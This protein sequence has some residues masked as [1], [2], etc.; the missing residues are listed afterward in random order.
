MSRMSNIFIIL[1]NNEHFSNDN[2]IQ[3]RIKKLRI[4]ERLKMGV[5]G[6]YLLM[7]AQILHEIKNALKNAYYSVDHLKNS[8]VSNS[9][10]TKNRRLRLPGA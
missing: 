6:Y 9:V 8:Q 2:E 7:F 10:S 4:T 1:T 3:V 5:V